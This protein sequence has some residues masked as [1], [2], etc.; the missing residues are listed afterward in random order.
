MFVQIH[1]LQSLP[2]G[3]LNRDDTG[4]PKKCI[5]G[6]VTRG[7][8]SSQCLKRNIRK[9]TI[10]AKKYKDELAIRT[11]KFPSLVA[12][13]LQ[14]DGVINEKEAEALMKNLV[15]KFSGEETDEATS[16]K[17]DASP[18]LTPQLVFFSN[19]FAESVKKILLEWKNSDE[20]EKN[21]CY[22]V[23]IGVTTL[24]K[25]EKNR[26]E[27]PLVEAIAAASE[28]LTPDI[29][30]FG[31]MTT[32]DLLVNVEA[33]CQAAHA[34]GT[35][36]TVIE[37]DYF[38]AMDDL[39]EGPGA[40]FLGSGDTVTFFDSAVYYK[41][42]NID[43]D[44]LRDKGH[45]TE[46]FSL[47]D[48]ADLIGFFL[49]AA[50]TKN[51]TG[52]QNA[53]AAHGQPELILVECSQSKQP[54]SYANAFLQAVSGDNYMTASAEALKAY[55]DSVGAA[56]APQDLSSIVLQ[57]GSAVEPKLQDKPVKTID[58]LIEAVKAEIT[59]PATERAGEG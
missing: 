42:F 52:K 57:V 1:M 12:E 56:Y 2:P 17:K 49:R 25:K 19:S 23:L 16:K 39:G 18:G 6:G 47:E 50:A 55:V 4:Q 32:S 41:Y 8:I 43:I 5:F 15:S 22:N 7:R 9:S 29:A 14:E 40:A 3:N 46:A 45:L 20:K 30:L 26:L 36:E 28:K 44:S 10:F 31:R 54:I 13:M 21:K 37:G 34:I 59:K 24:A 51:P 35:H 33:T 27:K 48:A 38:T 58:E 53:F 11:Q